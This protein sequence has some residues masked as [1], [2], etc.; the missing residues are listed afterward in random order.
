MHNHPVPVWYTFGMRLK[1]DLTLFIASI[2]WG[3]GFIAQRTGAAEVGPFVYN[4]ARWIGGAIIMLPVIRFK[5][6]TD[7]TSL[8]WMLSAGLVLFAASGFQQA[9]LTTTSAGNAGFIT[10]AYVVLIPILLAMFW[11]ER[12]SKIIW[13]AVLV[14]AIGIYLLS[15][16]G[17]VKLNK[18]D[19]Y[20]LLGALMWAFH[21][22][23][24]GKA[25]K[26][27]QVLPFVVG[28][29]V[30]CA[31]LNTAAGL[32]WQVDTI[33]ALQSNWL[34]I[35]YLAIFSTGLGFTFQAFGQRHA[36]AAD[37]AII[38]SLEAVFAA[39]FGWL[40]LA[41]RLNATQLTGCGL[42]LAAIIL[43]QA[44]AIR[45]NQSLDAIIISNVES[46]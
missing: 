12:T 41:E 20:E 28:Q 46:S 14:T 1:A 31:V 42:I 5:L 29:Y 45:K 15:M 3:F 11:K 19:F 6:P 39:L 13:L 10:G 37:A 21:V 24:T 40:F 25:V 27:V 9:G 36:P 8:T 4:A 26:H 2:L 7:K 35:V 33:P 44:A 16:S 43:S 38:M 32:L 23:L 17:P 30:I 34:G 22:I 18:G